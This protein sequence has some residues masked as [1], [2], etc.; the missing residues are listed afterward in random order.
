MADTHQGGASY[1]GQGERADS[2]RS[3]KF[4]GEDRR[5]TKQTVPE[6]TTT[7]R[8]GAAA[9]HVVVAVLTFKRPDDLAELLPALIAQADARP[10]RVEVL[11][12]DND[13]DAGA[14]PCVAAHQG[15]VRYVHEPVPGIAAAR[16][17]AL[18]EAGTA[19]VLVFVDDDERP[20]ERWLSTML[21]HRRRTEVVAV[22]GPVVSEFVGE[23]SHWVAAGDFFRRRRMP[24]GT[25]VSVAATNNLLLDLAW[26]KAQ[27]LRFDE[28]FGISGGEDTLFTRR[29]AELGGVME[30]ND[31]ALV[32]DR[33]PAARLTAKWVLQRAF[34][35]GNGWSCVALHLT[36]T[37]A[38]ARRERAVLTGRG[39]VRLVGGL[40]RAA[41]GVLVRSAENQAK[42]LRT[43]TRGLGMITGA[44]GFAYAEY[45]RRAN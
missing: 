16:N 22:V 45:R 36:R 43:A 37:P 24:T 30:W 40:L 20:S 4:R 29:I 38:Q 21:E 11:V 19:D 7:E 6:A 26:I 13:P 9:E 5:V 23:P 42:G 18:D 12:V 8:T 39:S 2:N 14:R 33:V 44:W 3:D 35:S 31:E 15:A 28:R 10:E 34:S 32:V 17:R 27:G 1:N 41:F 25:A